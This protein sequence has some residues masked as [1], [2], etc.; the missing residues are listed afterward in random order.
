MKPFACALLFFVLLASTPGKLD[1]AAPTW[2]Y[3]VNPP[4]AQP[5]A[6]DGKP[7][8]VPESRLAFT[9]SQISAITVQPPDWHPEEH[10]AMPG[11]VGRS[12]EPQVYACAYCHL[13]NGA[14]RPENSSLAGLSAGYI[15]AQLLA[16]RE[17]NRPGSEPGRAPQTFMIALAKA[18]TDA[19][20]EESAAYFAALAPASY[21]T[22][23]ESR[24]VP[25][26][27][28][29]GWMLAESPRTGTEPVGTRIIEVA[30]DF[31]RFELRDSRT[32]YIAY[33]P[34]GSIA[35]GEEL[36]TTGSA[37]RT[38]PCAVCHG[39]DLKGLLDVPRLAGRSPSYLFRQLYDLRGG[40][41]KGA[42]AELMK[43][44][45]ANLTDADMVAIAAY[46][47]SGLKSP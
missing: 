7:K 46:L 47:A 28:V 31:E 30:P 12:R 8:R 42:T 16:F 26:T 3:P 1:A 19:E 41:R 37:G 22:V 27:T 11:I 38:L 34:A 9:Q 2:A 29:A 18:L 17:G 44:V 32:P 21:V 14:G 13:P 20:I 45:V 15:K 33:A 6:D 5:V 36:V 10:P 25:R 23:I 35:R 24:T 43:P 39:P 4:G 40:T